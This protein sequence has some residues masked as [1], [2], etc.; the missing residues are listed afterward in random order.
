MTTTIPVTNA[1]ERT[2]WLRLGEMQQRRRQHE[3]DREAIGPRALTALLAES[4]RRG[5][6][7][8]LSELLAGRL[9][10]NWR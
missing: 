2:C 7:G 4:A 8:R 3:R 10:D 6:A 9:Y 5:D 1:R